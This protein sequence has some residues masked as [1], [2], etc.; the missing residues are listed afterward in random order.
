MCFVSP[1]FQSTAYSRTFKIHIPFLAKYKIIALTR[2][3]ILLR[4]PETFVY[5]G[6]YQVIELDWDKGSYKAGSDQFTIPEVN[7]NP[8]I[9]IDRHRINGEMKLLFLCNG[10]DPLIC[11]VNKEKRKI[12]LV[13]DTIR[14]NNDLFGWVTSMLKELTMFSGVLTSTME[15]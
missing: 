6:P 10:M 3:L 2:Q 8:D 9:L 12:E 4:S 7:Y 14:L 11:R 15:S 1:V 13:E 5:Y